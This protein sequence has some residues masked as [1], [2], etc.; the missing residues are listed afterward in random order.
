MRKYLLLPLCVFLL[1]SCPAKGQEVDSLWLSESLD[2]LLS[3]D[4]TTIFKL[5]D[6]LLQTD[7]FDPT[8]TFSIRLGYNSNVLAAG[9][10][11]A[12][13]NF[14]LS[15]GVSY[16]HKSGLYADVSGFW[17]NDFEPKYYLTIASVGYSY[18]SKKNFSILAN[19]D[20]YLYVT[21]TD[22]TYIPYKN[23]FSI[24]PSFDHKFFSAGIT[25]AYFFGDKSVHRIT[26]VV[27][28]VFE[29][30]LTGKIKR[31]ALLPSFQLLLGNETFTESFLSIPQ[32]R[33][34]ALENLRLYGKIFPT[35]EKT[36]TEF[37][38]MNYAVSLPLSISSNQ[39]NIM[40]NYSY[41]IP[42][43]LPSET[44]TFSKSSF[45]SATLSYFLQF[46]QSKKTWQ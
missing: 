25:Y 45:I 39:L 43:A 9:R 28:A 30:K 5:I 15:Q 20:R 41:S 7:E 32:T 17:S 46:R 2:F 33:R 31:V 36:H 22:N 26:P 10:T 11:L 34:E 8:S 38:I 23:S 14:G 3:D 27:S 37:G 6:S 13:E 19:Y 1:S 29:K 44:L 18:L 35:L 16:Y 12:I 24:S 21:A 42:K 4:T 40:I